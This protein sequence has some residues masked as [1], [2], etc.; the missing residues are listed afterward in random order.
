MQ[1]VNYIYLYIFYILYLFPNLI[2]Y[3]VHCYFRSCT[4]R[5]NSSD[6]SDVCNSVKLLMLHIRDCDGKKVSICTYITIIPS[7]ILFYSLFYF[8]VEYCRYQWCQDGKTL[9][10]HLTHCTDASTCQI[11]SPR[12]CDLP[13]EIRE[14]D[15]LNKEQSIASS[16]SPI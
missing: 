2:L 14:L 4:S 13:V 3:T 8:L 10:R 11:C 9:A 6:I 12:L 15:R 5:H 1:G 16:Q 7:F